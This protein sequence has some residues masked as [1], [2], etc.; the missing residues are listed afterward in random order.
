MVLEMI[1]FMP[2]KENTVLLFYGDI[3]VFKTVKTNDKIRR[4]RVVITPLSR[5]YK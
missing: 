3:N 5:K 4:F 2:E 1:N